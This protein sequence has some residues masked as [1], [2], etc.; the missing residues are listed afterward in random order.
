MDKMLYIAASGARQI[1]TAQALN[2]QNIA[3]GSTSGFQADL[4]AMRSMPV[5][6]YGHPSRV[7]S[8]IQGIGVD[9]SKGS[10]QS[11]GR[12]LDVAVSGEGW[13]AVQAPDGTE[14]YTRAGDL[15]ISPS[16]LLETG[17]G[18][19]VMGDGGP[20][21]V[22]DSEK[23]EIGDDGT[24]SL[25]PLGQ[26]PSTLAAIG[27]IKL[28]NPDPD[29]LTKGVDGLLRMQDGS[30]PEAASDVRLVSGALESSNVNLVRAMV[31]MIE[32]ARKFEAHI[33]LL[34]T[35]RENDTASARIMNVS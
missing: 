4:A 27:R 32:L 34:D 26:D 12:E 15:R 19:P 21:I 3:N 13:I 18:Y 14:A 17:A 16:G 1:M 20:I 24:V 10:L 23:I 2:T 22:P 9:S 35:A 31:T 29:M 28:V 6:G 30:I 8:S 5:D 25:L 11:T 33:K 7:F